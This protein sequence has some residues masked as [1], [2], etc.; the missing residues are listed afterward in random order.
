MSVYRVLRDQRT[1]L[2][3][4]IAFAWLMLVRVCFLL[5]SGVMPEVGRMLLS[6]VAGAAILAG[7][8]MLARTFLLRCALVIGLGCLMMTAAMHLAAH[9]TYP[10]L[11]MV[12][13]S[14][15]P[16]FLA[17]SVLNPQL[18]LLPFYLG[19]A[20]LLVWVYRRM[21]PLQPHRGLFSALLIVFTTVVYLASSHSLTTARNNIVASTLAQIPGAIM[22]PVGSL[23]GSK[24]AEE[25]SF[26]EDDDYFQA[27]IAQPTV[28]DPPNVLLI[29]VEG[30]SAG[31]FPSVSRYHGLKPLISLKKLEGTLDQMG[32][33]LYRNVLS[34]ERQTNRGTFAILCGLYPD[35]QRLA[36]KMEDV[37]NGQAFPFCMPE[38]LRSHGYTTAYWQAAPLEYMS[39]DRFMPRIGFSQVTGVDAFAVGTKEPDGWGPPDPVY[40]ANVAQRLRELDRSESRW[41]VTLLNV[42]THH[43]FN[44]GGVTTK[45]NDS[46]SV[47]PTTPQEAR[48]NAL[49]VMEA[50][51]VAFLT[52]LEEDGVLS[53]TLV[54]LT[55][56]ESGGFVRQDQV[57]FPLNGNTGLLAIRPPEPGQLQDYANRDRIA[58]QLDI[59]LTI[60]DATGTS[61]RSLP[62]TGRSLLSRNNQVE[63]ELMLAD[64]YTGMKFFLR[65]TGQLLACTES[66]IR[67]ETWQ[68]EPGRLFG[69]LALADYPPFLT[70]EQRLKLF[71]E[72]AKLPAGP[73][74]DTQ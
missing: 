71:G 49:S 47:L 65:E 31:Y 24:V 15:D 37:A 22:A 6:D 3:M 73:S 38:V 60:L 5:H 14:A 7:L 55:S 8:L 61:Q 20:W 72:A 12:S 36:T 53:N 56:D 74:T 25:A 18:L 13:K 26:E 67:C 63:R 52:G 2:T 28:N 41:L 62:M 29:M 35:F 54:V 32:F 27:D 57:D 59:P 23:L 44:T 1:G 9:G 21:V 33:R 30:L 34:M 58:A 69:T 51:L 43:P 11:A 16:V 48:R 4:L 46:D 40:F 17:S 64:T 50:E 39:K 10:R 70:L 42:G 45:V 66:L 19:L 68:F